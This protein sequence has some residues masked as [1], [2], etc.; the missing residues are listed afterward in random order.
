MQVCVCGMLLTM[1]HRYMTVY[2]SHN[3]MHCVDRPI[4]VLKL[5]EYKISKKHRIAPVTSG[6]LTFYGHCM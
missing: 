2:Y 3:Y 1:Y 4:A 5:L 6:S